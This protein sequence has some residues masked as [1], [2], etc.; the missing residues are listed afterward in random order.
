MNP[1]AFIALAQKH[2][3]DLVRK[4]HLA[5]WW[6]EVEVVPPSKLSDPERAAECDMRE[7]YRTATLRFSRTAIQRASPELALS[8]L[9]HEVQHVTGW[10]LQALERLVLKALEEDS[11]QQALIQH[12]FLRAHELYR[13]V[14]GR[15]TQ[16]GNN[17]EL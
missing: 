3:P 5:E 16:A 4:Y 6:L 9:E 8:Y 17:W 13:G 10:W 7:E 2:L 11:V 15:L 12:E 14:L 1:A